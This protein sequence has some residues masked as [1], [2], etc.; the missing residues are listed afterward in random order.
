MKEE[1]RSALST[2][3][4]L[5]SRSLSTQEIIKY[6]KKTEP[7][8]NIAKIV[9]NLEISIPKEL[10]NLISIKTA[11]KTENPNIIFLAPIS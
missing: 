8:E 9:V 7:L 4:C 3:F 2:F 1:K 10:E 11:H 5:P 6:N